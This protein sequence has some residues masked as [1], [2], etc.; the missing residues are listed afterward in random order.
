MPL[1]SFVETVALGAGAWAKLPP[2]LQQTFIN[3]APTY[4]D[5]ARDPET[6]AF[7]LAWI[8]SFTRPSLLTAG[9]QSPPTFAPVIGK[10][11]AVL[12][13]VTVATFPGASHIPHVTHADAYVEAVTTFIRNHPA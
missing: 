3:N 2:A 10:L 13:N 5:E 6:L 12:P 7:D 11:A 8:G 4:L 1:S 9:D